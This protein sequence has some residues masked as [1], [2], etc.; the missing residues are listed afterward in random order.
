MFS[1]ER[2]PHCACGDYKVNDYI[3]DYQDN[4]YLRE[5]ACICA[6]CKTQFT[7]THTYELKKVEVSDS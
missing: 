4:Y 3:D 2:C 6:N 1:E 7:I 5:W